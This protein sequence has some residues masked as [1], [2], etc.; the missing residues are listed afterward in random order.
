[1]SLKF[2]AIGNLMALSAL[3]NRALV[4]GRYKNL[5]PVEAYDP[6]LAMIGRSRDAQT[7]RHTQISIDA[8]EKPA[9]Y[10][11]W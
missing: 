4:E 7:I 9:L 6:L 10:A 2:V 5:A 8:E 1:M 3:E 11:R